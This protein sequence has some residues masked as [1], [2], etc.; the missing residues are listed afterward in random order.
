[1]AELAKEHQIKVILSSVLPVY[2][3]P[4]EKG[5]YPA[6]KIAELNQ[7][8]KEYCQKHH[9]TYLDYYSSMAD[10]RKGLRNDLSEDGV[11]PNIKGY[12]VME[13]LAKKAIIITLKN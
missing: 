1:M 4:W 13:P 7:I 12:Q 6:K 5:I 9:L 8:I 11:H 10:Q 3:Y 2:D